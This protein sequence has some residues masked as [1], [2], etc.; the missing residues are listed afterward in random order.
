[1]LA[2]AFFGD[3]LWSKPFWVSWLLLAMAVRLGRE[4]AASRQPVPVPEA[5]PGEFST[6]YQPWRAI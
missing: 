6:R 2:N 5:D 4:S 3:I 1:V